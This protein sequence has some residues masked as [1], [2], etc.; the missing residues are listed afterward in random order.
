M[1]TR[2]SRSTGM[3]CGTWSTNTTSTPTPPPTSRPLSAVAAR[4]SAPYT[5]L[6]AAHAT[7]ARPRIRAGR[8]DPATTIRS[9]PSSVSVN[10]LD[11]SW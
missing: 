10:A 11:R 4:S 1:G 3:P 9:D 8:K 5:P 2:K 6:A 7:C